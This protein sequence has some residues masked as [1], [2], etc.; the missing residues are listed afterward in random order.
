MTVEFRPAEA[1]DVEMLIAGMRGLYGVSRFR[2]EPTRQALRQLLDAPRLGQVVLTV[3]DGRIAGYLVITLA[4]SLEFAGS[5]A[6]LDELYL[7]EEYRGRGLGAAAIEFAKNWCR[8]R[9]IKALRL[10][11]QRDNA[12]AQALYRKA[13]FVAHDRDLMTCWVDGETKT[14]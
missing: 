6:L 2:E 14:G 13:G 3:C 12:R 11:V 5:F 4:C 10:E 8:Q 1:G 7:W 9:G